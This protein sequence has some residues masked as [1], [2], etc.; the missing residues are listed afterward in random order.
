MVVAAGGG[1]VGW[2]PVQPV[3][4]IEPATA[5][6]SKD[7]DNNLMFIEKRTPKKQNVSYNEIKQADNKATY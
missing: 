2:S 1:V 4:A 6:E 5:K 3:N 7:N